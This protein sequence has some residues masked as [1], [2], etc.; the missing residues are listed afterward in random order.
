MGA[1]EPGIYIGTRLYAAA[2]YLI[3]EEDGRKSQIPISEILRAADIPALTYAQ[4]FA[5]KT[6]ANL[7]ADLTKKLISANILPAEF[8]GE[9]GYELEAIVQA[10]EGIGGNFGEPDLNV[11]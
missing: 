7:I 10:I 9:D 6:L 4:V 11:D 5:I 8:T 2:G 1:P 3:L